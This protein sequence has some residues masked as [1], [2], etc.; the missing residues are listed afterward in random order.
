MHS[1]LIEGDERT[2]IVTAT[3]EL[4]AFAVPD[5]STV[6]AEVRG[7]KRVLADLERVSFV[8]STV[9]SLI[10]RVAREL[11]EAG[12][13]VRIV[14]PH[15][16]ARRIFEITSLDRVLPIAETRLAALAELAA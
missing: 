7:T 11:T 13:E 1:V 5:L 8:D 6:F 10:V 12:A 9:L 15:G 4:D 14:L 2:A 16:S 3:G